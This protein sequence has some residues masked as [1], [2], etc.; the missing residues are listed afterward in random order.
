MLFN[1]N[2]IRLGTRQLAQEGKT[3]MDCT[4]DFLGWKFYEFFFLE[5]IRMSVVVVV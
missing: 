5:E 4:H 2:E 3:K 1:R